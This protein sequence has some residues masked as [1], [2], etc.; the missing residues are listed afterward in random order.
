MKPRRIRQSCDTNSGIS[1]HN[2]TIRVSISY[3]SSHRLKSPP[4]PSRCLLQPTVRIPSIQTPMQCVCCADDDTHAA[5]LQASI[6]CGHPQWFPVGRHLTLS[7]VVPVDKRWPNSKCEHGGKRHRCS[8]G[9]DKL[10]VSRLA[11][12]WRFVA[13]VEVSN[14]LASGIA[15]R[16]W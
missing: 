7:K 3:H 16:V 5:V 11:V 4:S 14:G 12:C 15:G 2:S 1:K 9:P 13:A 8:Y 10:G 6:R